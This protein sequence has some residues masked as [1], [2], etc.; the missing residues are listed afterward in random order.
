MGYNPVFFLFS[1]PILDKCRRLRQ[2]VH[3]IAKFLLSMQQ[4]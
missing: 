3:I 2:E 4:I 1:S